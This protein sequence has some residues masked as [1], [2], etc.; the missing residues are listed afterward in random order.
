MCAMR[1]AMC[2]S[3]AWVTLRIRVLQSYQLGVVLGRRNR[4]S[5]HLE[6]C[7]RPVVTAVCELCELNLSVELG[8]A[9]RHGRSAQRD[10][11]LGEAEILERAAACAA[12]ERRRALCRDL[13]RLE[14]ETT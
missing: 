14:N 2:A 1:S 12:H 11:V 4:A 8:L 6:L 13:I 5:L 7:C 3:E 10:C 9:S